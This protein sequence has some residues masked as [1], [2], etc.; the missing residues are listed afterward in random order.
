MSFV[1]D[2]FKDISGRTARDAAKK[3]GKVQS[4]AATEQAAA[5]GLVGQQASG[6]CRTGCYVLP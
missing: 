6:L 3:A 5:L 2:F 4:Q 1:S